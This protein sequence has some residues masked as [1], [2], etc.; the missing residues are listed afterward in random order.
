[1]L[2]ERCARTAPAPTLFSSVEGSSG[3]RAAAAPSWRHFLRWFTFEEAFAKSTS[4]SD[5]HLP[6]Y[7]RKPRR[8]HRAPR[9]LWLA[10]RTCCSSRLFAR[11]FRRPA[12]QNTDWRRPCVI[13][14]LQ[15]R[16]SRYS[17]SP[18]RRGNWTVSHASLPCRERRLPPAS[19]LSSEN[20]PFPT[21]R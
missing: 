11:T 15:Q 17:A 2:A 7:P 19:R 3:K 8:A 18:K 20:H 21:L 13:L 16:W 5:P 4:G 14:E 9:L 6:F 12:Q 1:M 10:S